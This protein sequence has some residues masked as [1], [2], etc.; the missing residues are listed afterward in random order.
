VPQQQLPA[1]P[2]TARVNAFLWRPRRDTP[3]E[4]SAET[5]GRFLRNLAVS[6]AA[7]LALVAGVAFLSGRVARL[8]GVG[9]PASAPAGSRAGGGR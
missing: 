8:F 7:L 5:V 4:N 3:P 1:Q 2:I 6:G 9:Q